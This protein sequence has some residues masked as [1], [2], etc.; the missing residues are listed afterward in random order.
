MTLFAVEKSEKVKVKH[1]NLLAIYAEVL[2]EGQRF[3]VA[4]EYENYSLRNMFQ[5]FGV[6]GEALAKQ[7]L[8]QIALGLNHLHHHQRSHNCVTAEAVL[9]D[10]RGSLFVNVL[11]AVA[12]P[13]KD[14]FR[15]SQLHCFSPEFL[16]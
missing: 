2:L 7:Y 11:E 1:K 8:R 6:L 9:Y 14:E 5:E 3:V 15:H 10:Q 16:L 13:T 12:V 4:D